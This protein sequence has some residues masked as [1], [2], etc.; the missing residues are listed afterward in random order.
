[1]FLL[2]RSAH[3]YAPED[4]GMQDI[5]LCGGRIVRMADHI[6]F[7]LPGARVTEL[8]AAGMTAVPGFLD[9]HVHLTGGGGEQS[10]RS[11]IRE[12]SL[13]DITRSGVTTVVG[14]LGTDGITRSVENLVAKV[15]AVL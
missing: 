5:L 13:P 9:Q 8:S 4:R 6:D 1:M 7:S 12:L 2:I 15:K 14:V 11:R 3:V 10:F